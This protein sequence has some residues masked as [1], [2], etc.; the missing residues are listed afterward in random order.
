MLFNFFMNSYFSKYRV[1][2]FQFQSLCCIPFIFGRDV[3]GH[4]RHP[5]CFVFGTF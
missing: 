1:E 2:F 4:A 5:A 3:T